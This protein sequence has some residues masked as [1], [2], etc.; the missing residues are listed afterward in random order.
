MTEK[1]VPLK[2]LSTGIATI[3]KNNKVHTFVQGN[4]TMTEFIEQTKKVIKEL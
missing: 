4:L 1:D 2:I 3:I